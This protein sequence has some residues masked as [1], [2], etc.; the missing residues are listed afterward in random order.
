MVALVRGT[1]L[2]KLLL[3]RGA[4][5]PEIAAA[6]GL[7]LLAALAHA[8]SHGVVHRDVKPENILIDRQGRV[9]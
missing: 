9:D 6:V 1:T 5:P 2:R 7:E 8:N 3:E 4:M